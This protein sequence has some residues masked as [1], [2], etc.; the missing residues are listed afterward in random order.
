MFEYLESNNLEDIFYKNA[1]RCKF[2]IRDT[3]NADV[4]SKQI[5]DALYGFSWLKNYINSFTVER[6]E[7]YKENAAKAADNYF[8]ALKKYDN[9][10]KT[11]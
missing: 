1:I 5:R 10:P 3:I 8:D 4:V 2:Y 7:K 6:L 9:D 11:D